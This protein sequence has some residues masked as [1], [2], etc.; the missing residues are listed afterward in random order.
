MNIVRNLFPKL[1]RVANNPDPMSAVQEETR[2][3]SVAY[4][5]AAE[6]KLSLIRA[7]KIRELSMA[8]QCAQEQMAEAKRLHRP[9]AYLQARID[10]LNAEMLALDLEERRDAQS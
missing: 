4:D 5:A 7:E 1:R 9:T 2:F 6:F 3:L 8:M 10:R